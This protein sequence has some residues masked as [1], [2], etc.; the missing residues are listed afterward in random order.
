MESGR[1]G[2]RRGLVWASERRCGARASASR[3]VSSGPIVTASM[4]IW[5]GLRD[6]SGREVGPRRRDG[7]V[8]HPLRPHDVAGT[9]PH[10]GG[11]DS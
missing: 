4:D 9:K 7:S 2:R 8:R 10:P 6:A 11:P 3:D 5:E 1:G